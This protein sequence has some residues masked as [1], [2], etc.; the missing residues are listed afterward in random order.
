[1][2]Q[3]FSQYVEKTTN[4]IQELLEQVRD[5][6]DITRVSEIYD[7]VANHADKAASQLNQINN[8]LEGKNEG[9]QGNE[10]EMNDTLQKSAKES[11]RGGREREK[12]GSR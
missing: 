11:N 7:E 3:Q 8:L 10:N 5:E 2:T 6:D 1:M 12:A 9:E 4:K